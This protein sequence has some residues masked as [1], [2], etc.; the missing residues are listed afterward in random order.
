L[1]T[2]IIDANNI[3]HAAFHSIPEN[4]SSR[5]ESTAVIFGFLNRLKSLCRK[6]NCSK[7]YI[8]FD[9]HKSLRKRI[10]PE[11]K[12]GERADLTPQE[13]AARKRIYEQILM[14]RASILPQMGLP[15]FLVPGF[16]ADDLI[17]H[18]NDKVEG[19]KVIVSSDHDLFQ[20]LGPS[21]K[22]YSVQSK[23]ITTEKDFIKKWD[24]HASKWSEVKAWAGCSTDNVKGIPGVAEKTAIKYI[25]GLMP[26]TGKTYGK[27]DEF[28]KKGLFDRNLQLVSLPLRPNCGRKI[29]LVLDHYPTLKKINFIRVFDKYEMNVFLKNMKDWTKTFNLV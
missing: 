23:K 5:E 28:R 29:N 18:I 21:T 3:C 20:C 9:S 2:L 14:L 17:A 27:F 15:I 7:P 25:C 11:Y 4:L 13:R 12:Q 1:K 24:I 8:C 6:F 26:T 10:Y 22:I 16:E 19:D